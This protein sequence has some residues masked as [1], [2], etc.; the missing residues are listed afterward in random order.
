MQRI[1]I[2]GWDKKERTMLR[3][4]KSGDIFCFRT[5]EKSYC[6]G[7]IIAKVDAGHL[8]EI[9]DYISDKPY[10]DINNIEK[11]VRLGDPIVLD[12][13]SLFDR[14]AEGDWRIIG[15]QE[16]YVPNDFQNIYLTFGTGK[17]WEKID[18]FGNVT[19]ISVEEHLKYILMSP[20][21]NYQINRFIQEHMDELEKI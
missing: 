3:Y 11:A 21:G 9:L 8:T 4:L 6:F 2:W 15:H 14:K 12:S 1:R 10:I 7:R 5:D 19:K 17:E 18:L 20:K 16:D 13:Y